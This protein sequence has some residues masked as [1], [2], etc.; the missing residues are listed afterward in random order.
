MKTLLRFM[1]KQTISESVLPCCTLIR[2]QYPGNL[3]VS[4]YK[5]TSSISLEIV[6]LTI[7]NINFRVVSRS[8]ILIY[9]ISVQKPNFRNMNIQLTR[10]NSL[11]T[12]VR[13][14]YWIRQIKLITFPCEVLN[15]FLI[16]KL[17]NFE[18][19]L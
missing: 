19:A 1:K 10:V 13:N 17:K 14:S 16:G 5:Y 12:R 3:W 11:K 6:D 18:L 4:E 15:S 9:I 8:L 7:K 2:H